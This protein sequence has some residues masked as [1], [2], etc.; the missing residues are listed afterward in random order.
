MKSLVLHKVGDLR[1]EEAAKPVPRENEVLVR[2]RAAGICGS[3]IDRVLHKG[4][5]SFPLIPG[6]EFS[7]QIEEVGSGVSEKLVGKKAA[8]FPLLP[9]KKCPSCEIGQFAQCEDYDYIGSRRNG[10]F[11]EY[12][13]APV[14][15][16]VLAPNDDI[17]FEELALCEPTGIAMHAVRLAAPDIGDTVVVFGSGPIGLLIGLIAKSTR[18]CDVLMIDIDQKK[19]DFAK[20]L[21]F[22]A[23]NSLETNA[24]Q[25]IMDK[26][27]GRG[28]DVCFE[29]AGVSPSIESCLKAIRKFGK[30]IGVGTPHKDVT[31]STTAYEMLLRKQL[32]F[33]GTWNSVYSS[34]PKNEWNLVAKLISDKTLNVLPLVSHRMSLE[35]G[36][37]PIKM[38]AERKEFFN[39]IMY[40]P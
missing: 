6:H 14:W 34:L 39:K 18:Y 4:T 40:M 31:I 12:V 23:A 36:I 11:A 8:V 25:W 3:D 9:C 13:A 1:Y 29:G 10:A 21:G 7:G 33:I 15:N 2:V 5:Y 26:T 38:M 22:E 37:K 32:N 16:L 17:T 35:D 24:V 27:E 20:N 19:V 28:A 30:I